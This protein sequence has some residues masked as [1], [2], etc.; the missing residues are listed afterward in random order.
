V[1]PNRETAAFVP[2]LQLLNGLRRVGAA[3]DIQPLLHIV[4]VLERRKHTGAAGGEELVEI[5]LVK[6]AATGDG[7]SSSGI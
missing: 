2:G 3:N 1:R 7:G 4:L 6:L 5:E